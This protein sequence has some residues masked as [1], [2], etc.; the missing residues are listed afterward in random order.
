MARAAH[1]VPASH[2]SRLAGLLGAVAILAAASPAL[3]Q[4]AK[5]VCVTTPSE[6]A[7]VVPHAA[8]VLARQHKLTIV[9]MG[10][11]STTGVG[12]S[13]P[14]RT[15]PARLQAALQ[16]RFP[17][18]QITVHNRG[19]N[20]EDAAENL[21]RFDRDIR[22]LKPD[23]VLWQVGTN[24]VLRNIG[25]GRFSEPLRRGIELIRSYGADVALIDPQYSV[26]VNLDSDTPAMLETI[27]KVGREQNVSVFP[28]YK[29]MKRWVEQDKVPL[30]SVLILDGLHLSDWSYDCFSRLLADSLVAGLAPAIA[31]G[32]GQSADASL[33]TAAQAK[34][35]G[36][37]PSAA[38]SANS[39]AS[40][41]R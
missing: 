3:A 1:A 16:A 31:Q 7:L 12:A 39:S 14:D 30:S 4:G 32:R 22:A 26:W 24:Y 18:A 9:A 34:P 35:E 41:A 2:R 37:R 20:G 6:A 38:R 33:A 27:A 13:G 10:S 11:S 5:P 25:V 28:R 29:V 15:Y 36:A 19:G 40:A 17:D 23:L 8:E 21:W